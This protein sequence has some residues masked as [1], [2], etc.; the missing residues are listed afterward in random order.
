MKKSLVESVPSKYTPRE[1]QVDAL[2]QLEAAW[3]HHDIFIIS[4]PVASG[5]SLQA[6]AV[7]EWAKERSKSTAIITPQVLLQDQYT[8]EFT[9]IPSLKGRARYS[10]GD[11][12]YDNCDDRFSVCESYC[13]NCSFVKAR[14]RVKANHVGIY[15]LYSYMF[16]PDNADILIVDEAHSIMSQLQDFYSIKLWQHVDGYPDGLNTQGDAVIWMEHYITVLDTRYKETEDKKERS[17][18]IQ[19]L[20]QLKALI[21]GIRRD[22]GHFF[23]E[24][25]YDTHHGKRQHC[26]HIRPVTLQ[27]TK[28]SLWKKHPKIILMSATLHPS[29]VEYLGLRGRSCA[30]IEVNSPIPKENRP[31]IVKPITQMSYQ[32]LPI[33][34][35][36]I[37]TEINSL[38]TKHSGKGI[39]HI[40][41]GLIPLFK[42]YLKDPR[43]VWHTKANRLKVYE[44]FREAKDNQVLM[45]CGM[46]EGIDLAG[47]EYEWQVI[48]KVQFPSLADA[49]VKRQKESEPQWYAWQ[50]IKTTIQQSGRICR[51]PTD[52]GVTYILDSSFNF[53]Y[54]RNRV[55]FPR[56]IQ[57]TLTWQKKTNQS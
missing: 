16:M 8:A 20:G 29:D 44:K 35:P 22:P 12:M 39:V 38:L 14:E 26:I 41:Y 57:E 10:C 56:Y 46:S 36:K 49:L 53:L 28:Q 15:N 2:S 6:V 24:H 42:K 52:Y 31:I 50:A 9:N 25:K 47:K 1:C 34:V 18:L 19:K 5:K 11:E 30:Y 40:T 33:A 27:H 13:G 45:A 51:T 3:N 54:Q 55:L 21:Q 43:F 17:K 37:C 4:A 48:A 23:Y 7:A 32:N